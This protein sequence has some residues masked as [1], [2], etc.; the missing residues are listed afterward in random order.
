MKNKI[1]RGIVNRI[2]P[3][4]KITKNSRKRELRTMALGWVSEPEGMV[5]R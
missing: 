5:V 3:R 4:F 2:F 1:P